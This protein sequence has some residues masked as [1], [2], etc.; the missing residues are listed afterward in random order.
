MLWRWSGSGLTRRRRSRR[1][2]PSVST[3]GP[4]RIRGTL[5]G[6]RHLVLRRWLVLGCSRI[7]AFRTGRRRVPASG[8]RIG[9]TVWALVGHGRA[10]SLPRSS[11]E[12]T[13]PASCTGSGLVAP[14]RADPPRDARFGG[15]GCGRRSTSDNATTRRGPYSRTPSTADLRGDE[16]LCPA[17]WGRSPDRSA[18]W[19]STATRSTDSRWCGAVV[20]DR[21]GRAAPARGTSPERRRAER[22]RAATARGG[23]QASVAVRL[24]AA[25]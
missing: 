2:W 15:A 3:S 1:L 10:L 6:R 12:R 17:E 7:P 20:A 5:A 23:V 9:S 19:I 18:R 11:D 13:T 16:Q 14:V 4:S 25:A 24:P 21:R 8:S 22:G